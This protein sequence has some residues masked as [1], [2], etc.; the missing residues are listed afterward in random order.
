VKVQNYPEVEGKE[1]VPGVIMRI[2]AGP[3]EGVPNFAMASLKY[4]HKV[5]P[6][7]IPMLGNMRSLYS[8]GGA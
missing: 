4:N 2:V 1:D 3:A 8:L 7:T 5:P 6:L